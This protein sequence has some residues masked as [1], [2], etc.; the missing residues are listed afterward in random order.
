MDK[1]FYEKTLV[2]MGCLPGA[3]FYFGTDDVEYSKKSFYL[4]SELLS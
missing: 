1:R 3:V 2:E 4:K